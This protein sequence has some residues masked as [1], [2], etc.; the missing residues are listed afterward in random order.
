[1]VVDGDVIGGIGVGVA[2]H[3]CS[4]KRQVDELLRI[5]K[6]LK[7]IHVV[8]DMDLHSSNTGAVHATEGQT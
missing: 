7:D 3:A 6:I 4:K 2:A 8:C 5:Q 1:M